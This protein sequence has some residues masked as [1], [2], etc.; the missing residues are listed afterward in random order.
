MPSRPTISAFLEHASNPYIQQVRAEI[1]AEARSRGFDVETFFADN[2]VLQIQQLYA[3]IHCDVA[4]RPTALLVYPTN[5]GSLGRAASAALARGIDWICIHRRTGDLEALRLKF[6]ERAITLVTPDQVEIGRLQGRLVRAL[7]PGRNVLY[8]QGAAANASTLQRL[9][10]FRER[11]GSS[12]DIVGVVDG[13]WTAE[14]ARDA[15]ERWLRVMAPSLRQLDA[16]V[17]QND[18]MAQ[19]A[20]AARHIAAVAIG[21]PDF[22]RAPLIGC[23]GLAEVGQRLVDHGELA[24]TVILREVGTQAVLA[25]ARHLKGERPPAE[26]VLPCSAYPD[27]GS[28][29]GARPQPGQASLG[30]A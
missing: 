8:V 18:A 24:A 13:N 26:V 11:I 27:R 6:P 1:E 23:D 14:G 17:A 12:H 19:G 9:A 29:A 5:D 4:V 20:G 10:G 28:E 25:L 16:I 7:A 21:R 3:K 30:R 22:T 15:V 2:A